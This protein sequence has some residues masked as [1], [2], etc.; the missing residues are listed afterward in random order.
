MAPTVDAEVKQVLTDAVK[1]LD[2]ELRDI[3]HKIHSNPEL[4]YAEHK[5]HD[6]IVALLQSQDF[7]VTP[8]AYGLETS[9]EAEYGSGGRL[10]VFNVEYDALP[11]IGHACGHNI[12][13]TGS[14]AGF[15]ATVALLKHFKIPGRVRALGTPAEEGGGGKIKLIDAGAFEGV[16]ACLMTHPMAG[17]MYNT[18]EEHAH[19]IPYGTSVASAKFNATFTGRTAHAAAVPQ[20]GINALDAAVLAYNGISMLRQQILPY[21]RIH[22]IIMEG[23][24][25][26]NVIPSRA[27]LD[28]NVR[29]RTIKETK[30]LQARVEKC[31]EGAAVATGCELSF[32]QTNTYAEVV[33]NRA[34]CRV[35]SDFLADIGLPQLPFDDREGAVPHP[36]SFSTDQGNVTQ[37]CPGFHP[38]YRIP[39]ENGAANHT[40]EFTAA[41][42]TDK[43]YDLTIATAKGMA[44]TAWKVLSDEDF[45]GVVKAEFEQQQAV[46]A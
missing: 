31:F 21:E 32:E 15:F 12:I 9:F 24:E 29:S 16:D 20:D 7:K 14:L 3:N 40:K 27:K 1:A 44:A 10:V 23:G 2:K 19:G 43:A 22:G 35:Y 38:V 13:A 39:S 17:M 5:A 25:K 46:R 33:P 41:A 30:K 28:Y 36:G 11:G 34:L 26:A 37:V 45:A 18:T 42:I 6:N 4:G 8:H